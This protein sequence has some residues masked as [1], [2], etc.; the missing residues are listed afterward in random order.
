MSATLIAG[1]AISIAAYRIN[2]VPW[3]EFNPSFRPLVLIGLFVCLAWFR[4]LPRGRRN[5]LERKRQLEALLKE[6]EGAVSD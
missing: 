4:W 1:L 6:L 3:G 5:N 2:D